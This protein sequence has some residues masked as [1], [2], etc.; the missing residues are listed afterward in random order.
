MPPLSSPFHRRGRRGRR[1]LAGAA[2]A[3]V[4]ALV[5]GLSGGCEVKSFLDPT[6][7]VDPQKRNRLDEQGRATPVVQVI[8]DDLDL[9][10]SSPEGAYSD[11]RDVR[12]GDLEVITEDYIIGPGDLLRVQ[13]ADF[14]LP[15]QQFVE[16]KSVSDTGNVNMPDVGEV[17]V[18]GLTES[19]AADAIEEAY[20]RA[21]IFQPGAARI[22]VITVDAKNRRFSIVG[23]AVGQPGRYIIE[24]PEYRMLDALAD[25]RGISESR[26]AA[27]FAFVI[28][29]TDTA[30]SNRGNNNGNRDGNRNAPAGGD[31]GVLPDENDPLRPG[32]SDAG[33]DW[34]GPTFA[35]QQGGNAGGGN[36]SD[37]AFEAPQE[38]GDVEVIRIPL[39]ELLD[40]Q[41]KYNIIIRPNDQIIVPAEAGGFYYVY[42]NA[43]VTGSFNLIPGERVT[44]KRA[45]ASARG[46]NAVAVPQRTQLVR[47]FGDQDVF[48]RVDLA[49]IFVGQDPDLYIKPGD[50]VMVGTNFPA[51]FLA[52]FRNA[53]RVTYGFGF[54]YDRNFA[55]QREGNF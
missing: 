53:F 55:R 6:Q 43:A 16:P 54:L 32:S 7:L 18:D 30:R 23:G 13:I 4:G 51:P 25:A 21:G 1:R 48:I 52:A 15:G 5:A 41:R 14:P 26:V 22:N 8:L 12:A 27:E 20:V 17:P 31:S 38:P 47:Q 37:F 42:G 44:L 24:R 45:I 34:D 10:V 35:V 19:E 39:R 49:K 29:D 9:G 2:A 11:A 33:D 40:G 36:T 28:R 46:L 3:V 50:M